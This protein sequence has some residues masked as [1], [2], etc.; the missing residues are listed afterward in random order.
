[1]I[2]ETPLLLALAPVIG[3]AFGVVAWFARR[4]RVRL[5]GGAQLSARSDS[6]RS[7]RAV[8]LWRQ[9]AESSLRRRWTDIWMR[10]A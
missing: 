2:F 8:R 7:R 3:L 1:M 6:A 9:K 5:A 10:S 4:R